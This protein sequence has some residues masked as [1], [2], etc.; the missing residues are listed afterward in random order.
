[1]SFDNSFLFNP[2]RLDEARSWQADLRQKYG[3]RKVPNAVAWLQHALRCIDVV[4]ENIVIQ[5]ADGDEEGL[6]H[7]YSRLAEL[8]MESGQLD[9]AISSAELSGNSDLLAR[10]RELHSALHKPDEETCDCPDRE[11]NTGHENKVTHSFVWVG[12]VQV[13]EMRCRL[14]GHTNIRTTV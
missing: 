11:L 3:T 7:S 2:E 12:G 14:C 13:P 10:A 8:F 4:K 9:D 6:K 5:T 1:M